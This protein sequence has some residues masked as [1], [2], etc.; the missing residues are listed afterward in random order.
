MTPQL[1]DLNA[2]G[3]QD[4]VMP[5]FEGT[6]FLIEGSSEG[7]K[8]PKHIVDENDSNVRISMYYD[9]E[10]NEYKDVDRSTDDYENDPTHHM[11]SI[12]LVDWDEDGDLDLILGAYEGA[13]YR[14]ENIGTHTE[15]R[16]AAVNHRVLVDEKLLT[17]EGGLATPRVVDWDGDGLFDLLCGGSNN[18]GVFLYKN[19]GKKGE[20]KFAKAETLIGSNLNKMEV[21]PSP[22]DGSDGSDA[23]MQQNL[24][25]SYYNSML[26]PSIDGVPTCPGTSFHIE[27]V[28]YDQDGD[29][30]LLVGAQ[31]FCKTEQKELTEEEQEELKKLQSQ[32]ATIQIDLAGIFDGAKTQEEMNEMIGSE[33]YREIATRLSEVSSKMEALNPSPKPANY[34][35]LYRSRGENSATS[36]STAPATSASN[37]PAAE[38]SNDSAKAAAPDATARTHDF[39]ADKFGVHAAFADERVAGGDE[40]TLTIKIH[41]PD[42]YHIYG[43]S[44]SIAPTK[45]TFEETGALDIGELV[46]I[47]NGRVVFD[48]GKQSWWLEG[49]VTLEQKMSVPADFTTATVEGTIEYMM[50][51]EQGCRP[52]ASEKFTATVKGATK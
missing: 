14:C 36:S 5:T 15:P 26:V 50:C 23:E 6:A 2:D 25:Q 47:P 1:V 7:W 8:E 29:L 11:T 3:F 52:P 17:I 33:E 43:A 42:G 13:L 16:F 44:N 39:D 9:M 51:N 34:I 48:A 32:M 18:G 27:A 37:T 30:D 4:M 19:T 40:V 21:P 10:E 45:I 31:S 49:V 46:A 12:A 28:D 38:T 24:M 41:V 20:P 22:N 35:W